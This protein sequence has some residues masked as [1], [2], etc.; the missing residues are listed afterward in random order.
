MKYITLQLFD[1]SFDVSVGASC[2]QQIGCQC[3]PIIGVTI[4]GRLSLAD[5]P[6]WNRMGRYAYRRLCDR[7]PKIRSQ[8]AN[9]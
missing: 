3:R 6:L 5:M 1:P 9:C 7:R 2:Y 4:R 8:T